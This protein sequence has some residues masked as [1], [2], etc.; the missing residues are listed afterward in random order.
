[1]RTFPAVQI[2]RRSVVMRRDMLVTFVFVFAVAAWAVGQELVYDQPVQICYDAVST[3]RASVTFNGID[4]GAFFY[5]EGK[6]G[7]EAG[8]HF[9]RLDVNGLPVGPQ[10][11]LLA[12][13]EAHP[14]WLTENWPHAEFIV[15]AW[16]G[17][18]YLVALSLDYPDDRF[19]ITLLRVSRFG[20]VLAKKYAATFPSMDDLLAN[21]MYVIGDKLYLF[22]EQEEEPIGPAFLTV[23][24]MMANTSLQGPVEIIPLSTSAENLP[25]LLGATHDTDKFLVL[26]GQRDKGGAWRYKGVRLIQVGFS[27]RI[28]KG[29]YEIEFIADSPGVAE[30]HPPKSVSLSNGAAL[31]I[32][33]VGGP[34]FVGDGFLSAVSIGSYDS[35]P[36]AE[37]SGDF[38]YINQSFKFDADGKH[39][40][41]PFNIG[42]GPGYYDDLCPA[43]LA[44][45]H[46]AVLVPDHFAQRGAVA[47]L[48]GRK[49]GHIGT[50]LY[51]Y[52]PAKGGWWGFFSPKYDGDQAY[53]GTANTLV[54]RGF[55]ALDDYSP[56]V[57]FSNQYTMPP[58]TKPGFFYF[59]AGTA[60]PVKD[61]R[62][63]MWSVVGGRNVALTG[64]DFELEDLPPVWSYL[65]DTKG[66]K[67]KL[68]LSFTTPDGKTLSRKLNIKP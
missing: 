8:L 53:T 46:A 54:F 32:M 30:A 44:G 45:N 64:P 49:G 21:Y 55:R 36:A 66:R 52:F 6:D 48:L 51:S 34:V 19:D 68:T 11:K 26:V 62:L 15:S 39:L 63:V 9:R 18:A 27:G 47:I 16:D 58:F 41:G 33:G 50:L 3:S 29:P 20:K 7:F 43:R 24:M 2:K 42:Y 25:Y 13:D 1:M 61:H 28:I 57:V 35:V 59:K 10:R 14:E 60:E 56:E 67:T 23:N 65:V 38:P 22:F 4:H 40:S 37:A 12:A 31:G 5:W 17:G